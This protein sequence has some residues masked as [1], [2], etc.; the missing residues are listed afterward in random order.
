MSEILSSRSLFELVEL[1]SEATPD[2]VMLLDDIGRQVSFKEFYDQVLEM[3]AGFQDMGLEPGDVVSWQLPTWIDSIILAAALNRIEVLQNPILPIYRKREVGFCTAQ[4][5]SKLLVVLGNFRGFNFAD[6]AEEIAG[7]NSGMEVLVV[8]PGDFPKGDPKDLRPSPIVPEDIKD[9]PLRWLMYTSGTTA[10][11]KGACHTD[12]SMAAVSL[13]MGERLDCQPSD[14]SILAF[15]FTHIGGITWMFTA[16]QFGLCNLV[17]E[18]FDP[19]ATPAFMVKEGVTI[20]GSGTPFHQAYLNIQRQNPD[21]PLFEKLR[22]CPGGGAPK[23][24]QMHYDIKQELGGAGVV[25]GWGLTEVPILTMGSVL[26]SDEKLAETEGKAMSGVDLRVVNSKGKIAGPGEEGEL[27]AKAPQMMKGYLD[28]D[29]NAEAFDEEGYFKTGD[30]GFVDE[31]GYVVITGRLKDIII[32]HGE[33]VSAKEIED[34]LYAHPKV[35]DVAVIGLPDEVTGE[36]VCAVV[37]TKEGFE[38]VSFKEMQDYLVDSGLRRQAMPEQLEL[39]KA[40][41]RNLSG[42]ILKQNLK[43]EY[44]KKAFERKS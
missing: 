23:P 39:V 11:P 16:L 17:T 10:D 28:T 36:R 22:C 3:A 7:E 5:K 37:S 6:M 24:P 32:R 4:A 34:L 2:A 12:A 38:P 20:A 9:M 30:L 8:A 13:G 27:R 33:N 29:L 26:D 42:K 35:E 15:P 31:A 21:Q 40:V 41:P 19:E 14:R 18:A 44:S 1:R 25:S 43:E